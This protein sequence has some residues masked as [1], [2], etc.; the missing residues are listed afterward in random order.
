VRGNEKIK[1][2]RPK[3]K[4]QRGRLGEGVLVEDK[5]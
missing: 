4:D 1:D 3:T 5:R 2:K